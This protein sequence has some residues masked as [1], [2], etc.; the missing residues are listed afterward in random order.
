MSVALP[1][2]R[3][4]V[5]IAPMKAPWARIALYAVRRRRMAVLVWGVP[6]GALAAMVVAIFPSIGASPQLGELLDS[7]PEAVKQAFGI[8]DASFATAEGYLAAELFNLIAPFACCA[9]IVHALAV[10]LAGA[11]QRATLDL[12]L[13]APLARR[14]YVIGWLIGLA[15]T[16]L[17]ILAVLAVTMQL[18]AEIFGVDLALESTLAGVLN[19][20]PLALFSGGLAAVMCGVMRGAGAITGAAMGVI[21]A[22]YFVEVLGRISDSVASVDA[23]SAFHYYGS[24][25]E[26]GIDA[27]AFVGVTAAGV[28]LAAAGCLLFERRD[29]RR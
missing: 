27:G 4:A 17:G 14:Q 2:R 9:F 3:A 29:L 13:S 20:W 24:A 6:L 21:V 19:L 18:A 11:E 16:L 5:A 1:R 15:V 25:I 10:A 8:T 7:Y 12:V 23:F 22:M 26:S 28:V